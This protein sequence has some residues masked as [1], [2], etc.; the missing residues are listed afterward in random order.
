MLWAGALHLGADRPR[1]RQSPCYRPL[2]SGNGPAR[3]GKPRAGI[4]GSGEATGSS[5]HGDGPLRLRVCRSDPSSH[6]GSEPW[7]ALIVRNALPWARMPSGLVDIVLPP[8]LLQQSR[9]PASK[10]VR[11]SDSRSTLTSA[12][13]PQ[14]AHD[15]MTVRMPFKRMFASVIGSK[16]RIRVHP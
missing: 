12:E 1:L 10:T 13:R 15:A 9:L 11:V 6:R 16:P 3:R 14:L 2:G 8:Q 5:R 4:L 7:N